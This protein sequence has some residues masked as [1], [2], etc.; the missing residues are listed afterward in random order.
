[1][2]NPGLVCEMAS[3]NMNKLSEIEKQLT[4]AVEQARDEL[5]ALTAKLV[6]IPTENIPPGGQ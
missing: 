1:M 3:E 5:I 6:S 4:E 2:G